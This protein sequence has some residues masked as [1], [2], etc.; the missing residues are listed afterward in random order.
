MYVY[1]SA[2]SETILS[3]YTLSSSAASQ[4][5]GFAKIAASF[6]LRS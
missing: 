4:Q 5:A 1:A 3:L 6:R 2:T